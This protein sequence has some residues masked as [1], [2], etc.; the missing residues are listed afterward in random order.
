MWL[1]ESLGAMEVVL[2][3]ASPRRRELLGRLTDAFTVDA[4]DVEEV[5]PEGLPLTK[6]PEYLA[7]L[8]CA[9]VAKRHPDALVIGS[10]TGVFIGEK[11]LGKPHSREEA[12]AMLRGLSGQSHAVITGCCLMKNGRIRTFSEKTLVTFFP[13]T[14]AQI[15]AYLDTGEYRDKAGAYGIQGEGALLAEGI[16]GCYYNVMGLP[17][18][19][20]AREIEDFLK[21]L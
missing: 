14:D 15:S 19:R 8:K 17:V 21:E 20:L 6:G 5:L 3:S 16:A 10:D 2:A 11:M 9:A 18:S 12:F 1:N 4:A 13:L 7:E